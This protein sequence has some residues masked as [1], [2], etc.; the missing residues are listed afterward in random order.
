MV[1]GI[2]H[3]VGE[4]EDR[5]IM[6]LPSTGPCCNSIRACCLG[7]GARVD[8]CL[9]GLAVGTRVLLVVHED[10]MVLV[11]LAAGFDVDRTDYEAFVAN[12]RLAASRVLAN[13][14]D[15]QV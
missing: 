11:Q 15:C 3:H 8:N 2:C 7:I 12:H 9:H 13:S 4:Q 1:V 10:H 6:V 5:A 14:A